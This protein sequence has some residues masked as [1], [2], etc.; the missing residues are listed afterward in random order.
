MHLVLEELDG[1][2]RGAQIHSEDVR[3]VDSH[4]PQPGDVFFNCGRCGEI[5][6]RNPQLPGLR[7]RVFHC[8]MCGAFNVVPKHPEFEPRSLPRV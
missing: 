5:V 8:A 7:Q 1:P 6:A 3:L 4:V 2:T